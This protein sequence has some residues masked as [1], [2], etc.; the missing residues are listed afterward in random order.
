MQLSYQ[1]ALLL[2]A[3]AFVAALAGCGGNGV[4]DRPAVVS[5]TVT[6]NAMTLHVGQAQEAQA[7]PRDASGIPLTWR[8]VEWASSSDATATVS[9]RGVITAVAPGQA[10]ITASS[11]GRSG[12]VE[13]T[14][15]PLPTAAELRAGV[16][17][18]TS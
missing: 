11:E 17:Q 14:V 18:A 4:T 6:P 5:V 13:V 1:R 2:G 9:Q 12:S 10:T 15:I 8:V 7:T 16:D 3:L